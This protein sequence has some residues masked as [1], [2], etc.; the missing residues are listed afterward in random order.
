MQILPEAQVCRRIGEEPELFIPAFCNSATIDPELIKKGVEA[1]RE[2]DSLDS[3]VSVSVYNM[4]SPLRARKIENNRVVPA[5]PLDL[6][7]NANCDRDSQGDVYFVDNSVFVVRPKCMDFSYGEPPYKWIGKNVFP[8][9][10]W[11]GLDIDYEW[12]KGQI[13]YWLQQN[14]FSE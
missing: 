14:G 10:N 12:Q 7:E 2:D 4:W 6:F 1:L 8:L 13:E 5:V 9:M 3:A 11:G